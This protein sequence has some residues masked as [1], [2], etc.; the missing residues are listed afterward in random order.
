MTMDRDEAGAR[1]VAHT[2]IVT[3]MDHVIFQQGGKHSPNCNALT[4][5]IMSY[6]DARAAAMREGC[7]AMADGFFVKVHRTTNDDPATAFEHGAKRAAET[8]ATAIRE[9]GDE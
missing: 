7:A 1:A 4:A 3:F 9:A 6:G 2:A 5:A 8:I